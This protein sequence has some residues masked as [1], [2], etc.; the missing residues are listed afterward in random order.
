MSRPLKAPETLDVEMKHVARLGML[1]THNWGRRIEGSQA[2][3]AG[4]PELA[5][6]RALTNPALLADLAIRL[7]AAPLFDHLGQEGCQQGMR[8]DFRA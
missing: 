8:T 7:A 2:V 4:Q 3:E 1:V 5:G 6:N